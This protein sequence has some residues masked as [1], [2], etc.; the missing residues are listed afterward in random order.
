MKK[1]KNYTIIIGCGRLGANLA[2][3]LSNSGENVL[4][5]DE[6]KDNFKRLSSNFGGLTLTGDGTDLN[7]LVEANIKDATTVI[8]VTDDDNTNIMVA[9]LAK[10][11]F[12][13]KQ[14]IARIYDP[15]CESIYNN[16][17]INTIC[18]ST[19]SSIEISKIVNEN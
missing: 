14:I 18:P 1:R 7:K 16:L 19:L 17:G 8:A 5:I 12:E 2:D 4:V 9:Q 11:L 3:S 15:E 10:E 13:T 6:N